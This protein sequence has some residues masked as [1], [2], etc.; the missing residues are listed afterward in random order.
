MSYRI[1]SL[2]SFPE[3]NVKKNLLIS[4]INDAIIN[5]PITDTV[6]LDAL[7]YGDKVQLLFQSNISAYDAAILTTVV[8]DH[9]VSSDPYPIYTEEFYVK[10]TQTDKQANFLS[11]TLLASNNI[12][13][14]ILNTG[15]DEF[16]KT[17]VNMSDGVIGTDVVWSS[18]YI[19][20]LL[21][22]S[23]NSNIAATLYYLAS[24]L[25]QCY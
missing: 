25:P 10:V 3:N 1:Y 13:Y 5:A 2:N 20:N 18:Y 22:S 19:Y 4:Q 23:I 9:F 24:S 14:S 11:S 16:Y 12:R 7:I 17:F 21:G 6:F 8:S 15:S